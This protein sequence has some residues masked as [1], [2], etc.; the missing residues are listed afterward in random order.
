MTVQNLISCKNNSWHELLSG[1]L[2]L[3]SPLPNSPL[4]LL[5]TTSK[6][7]VV[8]CITDQF[9]PLKN[10][11]GLFKPTGHLSRLSIHRAWW[12]LATSCSPFLLSMCSLDPLPLPF[13]LPE[14]HRTKL[15]SILKIKL[16]TYP[17]LLLTSLYPPPQSKLNCSLQYI[18]NP[19]WTPILPPSTI[20]YGS[21]V[22][23]WHALSPSTAAQW[24]LLRT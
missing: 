23:C 10:Y 7:N 18:Y 19:S 20:V 3:N 24:K 12:A 8:K 1:L 13:P 21:V 4:P 5:H 11:P 9:P 22:T 15:L 16:K 6:G 14:T 2:P 17:E